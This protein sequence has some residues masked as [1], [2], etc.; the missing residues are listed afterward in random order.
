[1]RSSSN[2]FQYAD[3]IALTYQARMFEDCE[4][5]L[6]EDLEAL[7]RFFQQWRLRPNPSK[8]EVCVFHLGTH[9]ANKKLTVKF[10][11]TIIT[12]VDCPKY[13]GVTLDR[14]LTY[15]PHLEKS[16]MKVNGNLYIFCFK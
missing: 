12:H 5:H 8:T 4:I 10:D 6:E 2:L 9:D 15:K 3:D 11:K 7:S 13:L 16:A 1:V 14:T